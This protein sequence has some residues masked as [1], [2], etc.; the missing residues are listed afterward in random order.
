MPDIPVKMKRKQL[1]TMLGRLLLFYC[2]CMWVVSSV[3]AAVPYK[4]G[5]VHSYEKSYAD[6]KRYR[7][8]LEKELAANGM[9]CEIMELF[10]NCDELIYQEEMARASFFIDELDKWGADLIAIFN[11][12]ATYSL[13]KCNNPKLRKIPVVF[14][15]VYHPDKEL[16]DQYPNVTGYVDIPDYVNTVRMIEHLMGK[17]RIVVM[18]GSGMIDKQMWENLENQCRQAGVATFEGDVFAH[19]LNH[20]VV[21]GAYEEEKQEFFNEQIDTTIVMRLMSET[22]PLRTVQQAARGSETY[23]MFTARTYNSMDAPEFFANPSFGT[24]NEGFGSNDK[25]L[26]GY[27]TPLETQLRAMAEGMCMR[28]RGEMPEQQMT[29]CRKQFV[30]NW[31]V[32]KQYGVSTKD[33][34]P[35]Y[36]VMY[37]PFMERYRAYILGISILGGT[38][39]I[40]AFAYLIHSLVH[41]RRRKREA[42]RKLRY[43]HETLQLAIEGG[44]TYAWRREEAGVSFDAQFY[45]LIGHPD[46]FITR[47]QILVFVHPDDRERFSTDFLQGDGRTHSKEQYRCSFDGEEYQWWEFRYSYVPNEGHMPVVTGLLQNIQEVKDHEAELI[48]ARNIAERMELKQSF[49]NNISHEIRTPLNAI[50]GFSNLIVATPDLPEEEKKEFIDIVNRNNELLLNLIS[51]MLDLARIESGATPFNM[52]E[53]DLRT[54]LCNYC[55]TFKVQLKKNLDFILDFPEEDITVYV[56]AMRLQQVILN[57]LNNANKFTET[58]FIKLG[59]RADKN[60]K[61]VRVFVEDSGKGIPAEELEMIFSRF[62]KHDE[63]TQGTGLGLSISCSIVER[64]N[65]RIEVES[66][67]GKGS[68][69]IVVLPSDAEH[70]SAK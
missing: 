54:L 20:R 42:L 16:I 14:S 57:L 13:L 33:L 22:L 31:N 28:L 49:L 2:C 48:Q 21:K 24:I 19:I 30:L 5:I 18:S 3:R 25:M 17:S 44:T 70:F 53:S 41:E 69:F 50:V 37:I 68:R 38:L 15:G 12:Q 67:E 8:I 64:M 58:G 60:G 46:T 9:E 43:K 7:R 10:L 6:A 63:F 51:D 39:V 32:M 4:I 34:P 29:Q 40:Y 59:Y 36:Q 52:C 62:Y 1:L 56:D 45:K 47:E 65:G 55:E 11:N 23:L 66:E 27:F 26:G 35:E 61:A